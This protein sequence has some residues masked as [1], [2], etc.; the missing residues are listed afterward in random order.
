MKKLIIRAAAFLILNLFF[1]SILLS[2][3]V[4]LVGVDTE[5]GFRNNPAADQLGGHGTINQWAAIYNNMFTNVTNGG[6]GILVIG[7][8]K[9][10]VTPFDMATQFW[11][12]IGAATGQTITFVN[13][14]PNITAQSFSGFKMIAVVNAYCPTGPTGGLTQSELD[15]INARGNDVAAF[16]CSGGA[17]FGSTCTPL[18]NQFGYVAA[19]GSITVTTTGSAGSPTYDLSPAGSTFGFPL[20]PPTQAINGPWHNTFATFPGFLQVLAVIGYGPDSSKVL[21][22]GG[23]NV[24]PPPPNTQNDDCCKGFIRNIT[25]TSVTAQ[26]HPILNFQVAATMEA[27]P[28]RIR[29]VEVSMVSIS[30]KNSNIDCQQCYNAPFRY[31]SLFP[32]TLPFAV[33]NITGLTGPAVTLPPATFLTMNSNPRSITWGSIS[34]PGINMMG[35]N[36]RTIK[37]S[38]SLPDASPLSCCGDTIDFCLRYKFTD[39]TCVVCDTLVC[40]KIVR[41]GGTGTLTDSKKMSES[42]K[43]VEGMFKKMEK[44]RGEGYP[45]T[46]FN[47]IFIPMDTLYN[48]KST[49]KSFFHIDILNSTA[50]TLSLYDRFGNF[51][52]VLKNVD[53]KP[54]RYNFDLTEFDMPEGEYICKIETNDGIIE[55]EFYWKDVPA[56]PCKKYKEQLENS[57]KD[58]K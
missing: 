15:A 44:P 19:L 33:A 34:G 5:C 57:V 52:K 58:N 48:C 4:L 32:V 31:G 11:T 56:C 10:Q 50:V 51:I 42:V 2:G 23:M 37:L 43:E 16:V 14:A 27:G 21:A 41:K 24:C 39:T 7:G 28:N 47:G 6:S 1:S 26:S 53:L 36:K 35:V 8:G 30:L 38:L 20:T 3:P 9:D 45:G 54:D 29:K 25:N 46:I 13:T 12:L 55:K 18:T 22:I 17:L 49:E 40:Y